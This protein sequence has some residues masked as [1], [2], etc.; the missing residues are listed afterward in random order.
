MM[1]ACIEMDK[2]LQW[3]AWTLQVHSLESNMPIDKV[4]TEQKLSCFLN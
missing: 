2:S 1:T 4:C 3:A